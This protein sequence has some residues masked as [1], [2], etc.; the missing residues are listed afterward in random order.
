M[1]CIHAFSAPASWVAMR[2]K[3]GCPWWKY[4]S[5]RFL[6]GVQNTLMGAKLSEYHTGVIVPIHASCLH[7]LMRLDKTFQAISSFDNQFLAQVLWRQQTIRRVSPS[8][9]SL[10]RTVAI[11]NQLQSQSSIYGLGCGASPSASRF[12]PV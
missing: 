7:M 6:T 11:I 2:W 12:G 5:N 4:L 9:V 8:E 10:R 1:G 3:G